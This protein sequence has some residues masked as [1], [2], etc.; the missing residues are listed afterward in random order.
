MSKKSDTQTN[1]S[2]ETVWQSPPA[3]TSGIREIT[4][5]DPG[6][7][8]RIP[9][10]AHVTVDRKPSFHL[11]VGHIEKIIQ[12]HSYPQE[13]LLQGRKFFTDLYSKGRTS[14]KALRKESRV[15]FIDWRLFLL[16]PENLDDYINNIEGRRR[17]KLSQIRRVINRNNP[18]SEE[19]LPLRLLDRLMDVQDYCREYYPD[20]NTFVDKYPD[21]LKPA[22][23]AGH[24][25]NDL[26]INRDDLQGKNKTKTLEHLT[27]LVEEQQIGV[28]RC[29]QY[30]DLLPRVKEIKKTYGLSSGFILRDD[31]F[32]YVLLPNSTIE[33]GQFNEAVGRQIY[34][35]LFLITSLSIGYFNAVMGPGEATVVENENKATRLAHDTVG[36]IMM[37]SSEI[38]DITDLAI[39]DALILD[40]SGRFKI[41]PSAVAV[42]LKR[43]GLL[44]QEYEFNPEYSVDPRTSSWQP[45]KS[46]IDTAVRNFYGNNAID[47]V[48]EGVS[49]PSQG[50]GQAGLSAPDVQLLLFG[51]V[52]K[53]LW[54]KLRNRW[55]I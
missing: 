30:S 44:D 29:N 53:P 24:I 34:T 35:L 52:D 16:D 41:T 6:E 23:L 14:L 45:R 22:R 19:G 17:A 12:I 31:Y 28:A 42:I 7:S 48:I 25:M 38:Q 39:D 32:P 27:S 2:A 46:H 3:R 1:Q 20:K 15:L 33:D 51:R 55:N 36:E 49:P 8:H 10:D 26:G 5:R 4:A 11:P 47:R 54:R 18:R 13:Y 40:L 9:Y 43:R 21:T 37:P 50:F